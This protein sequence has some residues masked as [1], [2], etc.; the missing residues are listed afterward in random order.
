MMQRSPY[1][2]PSGLSFWFGFT[3]RRPG[4]GS[5]LAGDL[6]DAV[7]RI[8]PAGVV[9]AVGVA[10]EAA[11]FARFIDFVGGQLGVGGLVAVDDIGGANP[12]QRVDFSRRVSDAVAEFRVTLKAGQRRI[13][14]DT[15]EVGLT[16]GVQRGPE[17]RGLGGGGGFRLGLRCGSVG[18]EGEAGG[19]DGCREQNNG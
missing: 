13:G 17:G 6:H 19:R 9:A 12:F 10:L 4:P 8:G 15:A 5:T 18:R 11:D 3:G 1:E 16:E 14:P 7:A 2:R